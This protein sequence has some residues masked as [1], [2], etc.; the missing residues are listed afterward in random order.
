MRNLKNLIISCLFLLFGCESAEELGGFFRPAPVEPL[1]DVVRTIVPLGYLSAVA[2]AG[3]LGYPVPGE[4]VGMEDGITLTRILPSGEFP[5]S[6]LETDIREIIILCFPV[7]EE[8]YI[9]SVIC[10][11]E[12]YYSGEGRIL[13]YHTIPVLHAEGKLMTVFAGQDIRIRDSIEL[14]LQMGPAEIWIEMKR[15]EEPRP[16]ST[17]AAIRQDA[18]MIETDTR[19]TLENYMDDTYLITGGSQDVSVIS[20]RDYSAS[21]IIQL[22]MMELFMSPECRLAPS[23]GFG[24]L[25]AIEVSSGPGN[26]NEDIVIG[27]VIYEF[28][29]KCTG[30]VSILLGT[31]SFFGSTGK[32]IDLNLEQSQ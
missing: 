19:G 1:A 22:A 27:S 18:W 25:Q 9:I 32:N 4:I 23:G 28:R 26:S 29:G 24:V 8:V 16:E 15:L 3:N 6:Y 21:G 7:D 10:L 11:L 31:G 30:K 12:G 13:E 5:L 14:T 2:V 17:E 20:G